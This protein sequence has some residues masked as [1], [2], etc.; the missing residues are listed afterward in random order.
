MKK[1]IPFSPRRRG[2][3][4]RRAD[5]GLFGASSAA[6]L[7]VARGSPS[8]ASLALGT[9]SPPARGEGKAGGVR[10]LAAIVAMLVS[11]AA[12]ALA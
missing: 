7:I 12:P 5:E 3:G 4:A 10:V 2:E 9:F 8:S 6:A 1:F 11:F